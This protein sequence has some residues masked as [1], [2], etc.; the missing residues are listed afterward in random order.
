MDVVSVS[1][2]DKMI[3]WFENTNRHN[4]FKRHII[5]NWCSPR[6]SVYAA[7][8][9]GDGWVDVITASSSLAHQMKWYA[10]DLFSETMTK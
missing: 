10:N 2:H 5:D 6:R 3:A 7:D 8:L 9:H 4:D 1:K